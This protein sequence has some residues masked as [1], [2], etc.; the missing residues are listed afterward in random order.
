MKDVLGYLK[1]QQSKSPTP[2]MAS[3]WHSLEDL[4]NRKYEWCLCALAESFSML[5][6]RCFISHKLH[7]YTSLHLGWTEFLHYVEVLFV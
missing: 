6:Y 5:G 4:H 7:V 1:Q 3:E 2:E